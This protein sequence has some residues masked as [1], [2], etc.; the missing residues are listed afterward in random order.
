M[1]NSINSN[2]IIKR[3][4]S[5]EANDSDLESLRQLLQNN[6]NETLQQLGKFNVSIDKGREIHIGD[7]NYFNWSDEA[8]QAVVEVVQ[9]G[10][11]VAVFNPT[12]KV[13]IYNYYNYYREEVKSDS[14]DTTAETDN[15]P[16]PYRGLF[17]FSPEDA[18]YFFGRDIF[19][20]ELYQATQTKRFIPV[21]GASG[22]GKSS[23]IF[24]GLVPKLLTQ[25]HW[26]FTHFRP[27]KDPFHALAQALV[28][29]YAQNLNQTQL[30]IQADDLS[31]YLKDTKKTNQLLKVF[32]KI[33]HNYPHNRTLLIADQFEEIYT[34]CHDEKTRHKFLNTLLDTFQSLVKQSSLSTVLVATMRADFLGDVLSD[35]P[36]ADVLRNGDIKIRSMNEKELREVIEKPAQKLGVNFEVGL[37]ER[38]FQD[39][40]KE[41]GNLPLL[42][43]ALTELWQK[44]KGKQLIHKAYEEIGQV[45]GALTRYADEKYRQLKPEE[46]QQV[47]RI[48]VQLVQPGE[49]TEDIRRVAVK[50]ELGE[51]S[52]SLVKKL[53][54]ARLVV[55]SRN[56]IDEETVEVVHE[57]LIRNWGKLREWMNKDRVF[58]TWQEGLRVAKK[59]WEATNQDPGS[60][61]RG[62]ALAEAEEKL[63]DRPEDL[64][65]EAEFIRQSIQERKNLHRRTII[66]LTSFSVVASLIAFVAGIGWWTAF[67]GEKNYQ[68]I[69]STQSSEALFASNKQFDALLESIKAGKQMKKELALI[70]PTTEM[71]VIIT[72]MQSLYGVKE[73]NRLE[74]YNQPF[75]KASFSADGQKIAATNMDNVIKIWDLSGKEIATRNQ[76]QSDNITYSSSDTGDCPVNTVS[77]NP[78]N[79]IIAASDGDDIKLWDFNG[80]PL[81]NFQGKG[82]GKDITVTSISNDGKLIAA[83][84]IN[85]KVKVWNQNGEEIHT[86]QHSENFFPLSNPISFSPD[87]QILASAD[88]EKNVV[89]WNLKTEEAKILENQG[90]VCS[91]NFNSKTGELAVTN[92]LNEVI[93]W[94][95]EDQKE[96]DVDDFGAITVIYS[97]EGIISTNWDGSIKFWEF[98]NNIWKLKSSWKIHS[99][100]VWNLS[101]SPNK[102][103]LVSVSDDK[104]IK[105]WNLEGIK[106]PSFNPSNGLATLGDMILSLDGQTIATVTADGSIKLWNLDGTLRQEPFQQ[107]SPF[108]KITFSPDGK[109]LVSSHRNLV[110]LWNIESGESKTIIKQE[111]PRRKRNDFGKASFSHNGK[112][113][114]VGTEDGTI[115]LLSFDGKEIQTLQGGGKLVSYSP[116][117]KIIASASNNNTIKLW[118]SD[119]KKL[120]SLVG[121]YYSITSLSFSPDS[122]TL[123]AGN[124]N[125]NILIWSITGKKL[126]YKL[127][128]H[129]SP[130]SSLTFRPD[131]KIFASASGNGSNQ[132]DGRMKFWSV[133]GIEIKTLKTN[134]SAVPSINFS[135]DGKMFIWSNQTEVVMWNLDLNYLLIQGCNWVDDYLKNNPNVSEKD[136]RL[137]GV[138]TSATAFFLQGKKLAVSGEINEA[139]SAFQKAVKLDSNFSFNSVKSLVFIGNKLVTHGQFDRAQKLESDVENSASDWN[140]LCWEGSMNEKTKKVMFACEKAVQLAPNNGLIRNSRD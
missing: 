130:V 39:I 108:S 98:I 67:R 9:Q 8:I 49:G 86:F 113:I 6:D 11:A 115:K 82:K 17:T 128:G 74:G 131:N 48:F 10:K 13:T 75:I 69:A 50:E 119:G 127:Q 124:E 37:V 95:I 96:N 112:I 139:V 27:G 105:L 93:F 28:P 125:G 83:V 19:I 62:A 52:W 54:D 117:G 138:E 61:L 129:T 25:G 57:A 33:Q 102:K 97:P 59:Q 90:I 126:L 29:L 1:E 133:E 106:P 30:I 100:P 43:F 136:R 121:S 31:E 15:L 99:A 80:R 122:K 64:Y 41:P 140:K 84:N 47:H 51:Q 2:D 94:S 22:S 137:C 109:H 60:L 110:Q 77:F 35:P 85:G 123:V 53:A 12:G 89:L 92:Y 42:E 55:T 79:N 101:F 38:I 14:V 132:D 103:M 135:P 73:Q 87:N 116:D 91:I 66:T 104:T 65:S 44:R 134:S 81:S 3:I 76:K 40:D 23:V 71:Q 111:L 45:S 118:S 20:E 78:N 16:C 63:A 114:A 107:V 7:R 4:R 32:E 21:L 26:Q 5:G 68:L 34:L 120:R 58:R 70:T 72:L 46:Q 24:A 36:L 56:A 18:E 88:G